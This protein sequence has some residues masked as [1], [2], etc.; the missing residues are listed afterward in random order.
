MAIDKNDSY[1]S[2]IRM[3]Q[4]ITSSLN[5]KKILQ[6]ILQETISVLPS[7]NAGFFY[8][9]DEQSQMLH[10][11]ARSGFLQEYCE[12]DDIFLAL[13]EGISGK[14]FMQGDSLILNG[15]QQVTACSS[16]MR[17]CNMDNYLMLTANHAFPRGVISTVLKAQGK[18]LGVMT[19]DNFFSERDFN[20]DDL[21]LLQAAADHAAAAIVQARLLQREQK[22]LQD[23][24]E[25]SRQLQK[26]HALLE[27]TVSIHNQLL[28][29][30]VQ[31]EGFD[32]VVSFLSWSIGLPIIIY[33]LFLNP[34][35]VSRTA[36]NKQLPERIIEKS[37]MRALLCDWQPQQLPL[38]ESGEQLQLLPITGANKLLGFLALWL[39]EGKVLSQLENI[40]LNYGAMLLA[41]E[42]LKQ[43]AIVETSQKLRGE[44]LQGVLWG[45]LDTGLMQQSRQLGFAAEDFYCVLLLQPGL[46]VGAN[47][48]MQELQSSCLLHQVTEQLDSLKLK[49]IVTE[50]KEYYCL[51]LSFPPQTVAAAANSLHKLAERLLQIHPSFRVAAGRTYQS[52]THVRNS[53]R[54]AHQCLVLT[55]KYSLKSRVVYYEQLGFLRLVLN[56]NEDEVNA[57]IKDMLLP[58]IEYDRKKSTDLFETLLNYVHCNKSLGVVAKKCMY[59]AIRCIA[60]LKK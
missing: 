41:L 16:D 36:E 14:T 21:E 23:L 52:L 19:I 49:G 35:A 10:L 34:V 1:R 9:Y 8:L 43:N 42:W 4:T 15:I 33:N 53:Y 6:I 27:Q 54:E 26:E 45:N 12:E 50:E 40:V 29:I 57:Y 55:D 18:V 38:P 17:S 28:N 44:F 39:K 25:V 11:R 60:V 20:E 5:D 13:G 58:I 24:E 51:L 22:H 7:A 32:Q 31:N 48:Y 3:A 46:S 47:S 59:T 37:G 30:A 56:S 2:L